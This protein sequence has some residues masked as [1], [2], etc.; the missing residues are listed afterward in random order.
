MSEQRR[1]NP[2]DLAVG[3]RMKQRR[4]QLSWS[5]EELADKLG[6]SFQQVQKYERGAN[7]VSA[8]R[9]FQLCE[10]LDVDVS[11]F[12]DG[13]T[14]AAVAREEGDPDALSLARLV[15][16][17]G[18]LDVLTAYG[19]LASARRRKMVISFA[20]MLVEEE[21]AEAAGRSGAAHDEGEPR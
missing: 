17:P 10:V 9:L 4:R 6:L 19:E 7:R 18:A 12:F 3:Q 20:R 5:Q 16:P 14:R 1:S 11:Y 15:A 13:L 8:G 2:I 21:T